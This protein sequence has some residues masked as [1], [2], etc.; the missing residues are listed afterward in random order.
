[1]LKTIFNFVLGPPPLGCPGEGSG[2]PSPSRTL[3]LPLLFLKPTAIS[4]ENMEIQGLRNIDRP[5]AN[6]TYLY[7]EQETKI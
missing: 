3:R 6:T 1:V 7:P 5:C 2:L 4:Y